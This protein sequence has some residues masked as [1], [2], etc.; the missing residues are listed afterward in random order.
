VAISKLAIFEF[1]D[2]EGKECRFKLLFSVLTQMIIS[3]QIIH[4]VTEHLVTLRGKVAQEEHFA[5]NRIV[6]GV[7]KIADSV[8]NVAHDDRL[9]FCGVG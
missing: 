1:R 7:T 2:S 6:H 9:V 3:V 8:D 4:K 5:G